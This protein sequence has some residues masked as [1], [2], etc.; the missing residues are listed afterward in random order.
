MKDMTIN[1]KIFS[2]RQDFLNEMIIDEDR[3]K[4]RACIQCGECTAGCPSGNWTSLKT[5][6]IMRKT[7]TGDPTLL[8]DPDLWFCTTCFQCYERCPRTIPV[9]NIILKVRNIAVREGHLPDPLKGIIKNLVTFGHAVPI[10]GNDSKW[11][12]LREAHNL[13]KIP[14][15]VHRYPE[16]LD[17]IL[18]L[19]TKIRFNARIPYKL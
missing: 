6:K 16:A 10:G 19:L 3:R 13:S 12:R 17:E 7:L 5:R 4:L 2:F 11:A 9:T 15:T 14:P 8:T 18:T 1:S